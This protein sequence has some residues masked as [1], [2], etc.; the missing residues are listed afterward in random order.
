MTKS[1]SLLV[2]ILATICI[3]CSTPQRRVADFLVPKRDLRREQFVQRGW[4]FPV[5]ALVSNGDSDDEAFRYLRDYFL[6]PISQ[7]RHADLIQEID[8]DAFPGESGFWTCRGV[9]KG[10]GTIALTHFGALWH[11]DDPHYFDSAARYVVA[12][13]NDIH[14]HTH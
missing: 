7:S 2:L 14:R 4:P 6:R 3:G 9:L 11:F 10:F 12:S 5:H 1:K 8:I 13:L